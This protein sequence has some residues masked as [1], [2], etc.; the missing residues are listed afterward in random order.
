M[1]IGY[2]DVSRQVTMLD[3]WERGTPKIVQY[4]YEVFCGLWDYPELNR[5]VTYFPNFAAIVIP[6]KITVRSNWFLLLWGAGGVS[7]VL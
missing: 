4:S 6:W 1:L 2:D 3:P 7:C 5:N